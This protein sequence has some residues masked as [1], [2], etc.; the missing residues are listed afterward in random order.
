MF[1]E[2][3]LKAAESVSIKLYLR[4]LY[5]SY[6][7]SKK[8]IEEIKNDLSEP[9]PNIYSYLERYLQDIFIPYLKGYLEKEKKFLTESYDK[10][11]ASFIAYHV[12]YS[13]YMLI[14]ICLNIIY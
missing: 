1:I 6:M 9:L 8:L 13:V 5:S 12:S 2:G 3:I 10:E 7:A 11:L 4:N 14:R